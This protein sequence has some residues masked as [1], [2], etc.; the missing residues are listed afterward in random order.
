M[1]L[2]SPSRQ[3]RQP[4][5]GAEAPDVPS[6]PRPTVD[7]QVQAD[8]INIQENVPS[9]FRHCSKQVSNMLS[10]TRISQ[11]EEINRL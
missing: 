5:V 8:L 9:E 10:E 7:A 6:E 2:G 1:E 3:E 4:A 11:E